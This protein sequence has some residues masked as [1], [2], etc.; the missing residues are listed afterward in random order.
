MAVA[1]VRIVRE[2]GGVSVDTPL[3]PANS[4]AA[5]GIFIGGC[6]PVGQGRKSPSRVQGKSPVGVWAFPKI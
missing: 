4:I 2:T 3:L 5:P 6:S 1:P